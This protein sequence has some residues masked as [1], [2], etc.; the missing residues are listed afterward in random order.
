MALD[1]NLSNS[2]V[3]IDGIERVSG[4]SAGMSIA[5]LGDVNG[6]GIP[7]FAISSG[8]ITGTSQRFYSYR[9]V[10]IFFGKS[11]TMP[12]PSSL[13][14][15]NADVSFT[16]SFYFLGRTDPPAINIDDQFGSYITAGDVNGDGINDVL[17]G[18]PGTRQAFL[19]LGRRS[20]SVGST[21]D[22][23]ASFTGFSG[24]ASIGNFNGDISSSGNPLKD[25]VIGDP[26]YRN[27]AGLIIGRTYLF[28]GRESGWHMGT[29]SSEAHAFWNHLSDRSGYASFFVGHL[30]ENP[31]SDSAL[32]ED[33]I[34]PSHQ[35]LCSPRCSYLNG[36]INLF[37]GNPGGSL[38]R[39]TSW[40]H[41]L[42]DTNNSP[43]YGMQ[44]ASVGDV[45]GDGYQDFVAGDSRNVDLVLGQAGD[46]S[47]LRP[48]TTLSY[49]TEV[50]YEGGQYLHLSSLKGIGDVDNDGF[51]DL[52]LGGIHNDGVAYVVLGRRF[53]FGPDFSPFARS[54]V[55]FIGEES[56]DNL[57]YITISMVGDV[58][59]GGKA[60]VLIGVPPHAAEMGNGRVYLI[61][62][63]TLFSPIDV[64]YF[65][66]DIIYTRPLIFP[67]DIDPRPWPEEKVFLN[68][69][70][71]PDPVP[72]VIKISD[73]V[74]IVKKLEQD[75][76]LDQKENQVK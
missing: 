63:E 17:I 43:W 7:D 46:L 64:I 53:G 20:W 36:S 44:A 72:D 42:S 12:W 73:D 62:G 22:A 9:R 34:I 14:I 75:V 56:E 19:F 68:P 25:I 52:L 1:F 6:D 69:I 31:R 66:Y 65:P 23:D 3:K 39:T 71:Q 11:R 28:L 70:P 48:S 37:T 47:S 26:E 57:N 18:A 59:S 35:A 21:S 24:V 8:G 49:S 51:S 74:Q 10:G 54:D 16:G 33:L 38:T 32:Y 5:S 13:T 29:T 2:D 45:N 58:N 67:D 4:I 30:N 60:D 76:V 15:G 55:R 27:T 50:S 61:F 41:R 40:H